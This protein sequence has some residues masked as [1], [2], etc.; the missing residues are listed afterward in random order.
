MSILNWQPTGLGRLLRGTLLPPAALG[1]SPP[2]WMAV[3]RLTTL[4]STKS[5]WR[6]LIHPPRVAGRPPGRSWLYS[7]RF[8]WPFS[9][10]SCTLN[11]A[12]SS[13]SS[14]CSTSCGLVCGAVADFLGSPAHI[15]CSMK[16]ARQS[17]A[18]SRASSSTASSPS[19]HD[20][21]NHCYYYL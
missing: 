4:I 16:D 6:T 3:K 20:T 2:R 17:T 19:G 8:G 21:H 15:R 13:S 10:L 9:A 7:A 11:S 1:R 12:S 14:L 5:R 18:L